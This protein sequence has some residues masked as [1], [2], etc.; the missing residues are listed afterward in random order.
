[1]AL[2]DSG[3]GWEVHQTTSEPMRLSDEHSSVYPTSLVV[4]STEDYSMYLESE[5]F[6]MDQ[7]IAGAS[8]DSL[9]D[10]YYTHQE[11]YAFSFT[12]GA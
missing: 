11:T 5:S 12:L 6:Y 1:M 10:G 8:W 2:A 3:M 4:G 7:V 9:G